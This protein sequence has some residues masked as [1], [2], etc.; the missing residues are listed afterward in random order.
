[1]KRHRVITAILVLFLLPMFTLPASA[2]TFTVN[3]ASNARNQVSN[4]ILADIL[5]TLPEGNHD[6]NSGNQ[7]QFS[8]LAEGWTT[9][10]DKIGRAHV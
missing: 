10:P 7:N 5:N 8:C 6:Q 4:T 9:D 2:S 3:S 1:M